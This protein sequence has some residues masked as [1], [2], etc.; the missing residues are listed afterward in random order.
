MRLMLRSATNWISGSALSRVTK[1]GAIFLQRARILSCEVM[2]SIW[3]ITTLTALSTTA[4]LACCSRG[5]TRSTMLLASVS[6]RARYEASASRMNTCPHSVHSLSAATSL[7]RVWL[8]TRNTS[9]ELLSWISASAATALATT[10]GL[11][12]PRRSCRVTRKPRSSTSSGLMSWSFATQMAAVFFTYGSSSL[13]HFSRGSQRY[14]V[15]LSTRMQP[16]V[17]TARARI[18]GLGSWESLTNVFTAMMA[19]SGWVLA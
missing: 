15:I 14:S 17:R 16:M 6:S 13:R 1:G 5:A 8:V 12:S 18:S 4:Q 19:R 7:N 9:L 10:I 3:R 11:E 2:N